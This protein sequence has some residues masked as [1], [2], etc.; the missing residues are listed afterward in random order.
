MGEAVHS[1]FRIG[2]QWS[3]VI[4]QMVKMA[5]IYTT[6]LFSTRMTTDD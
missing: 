3:L 4:G 6:K 2:G 1:G 5:N